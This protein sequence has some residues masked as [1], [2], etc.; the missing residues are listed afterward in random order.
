[1][2]DH[3]D[4]MT[5]G[6]NSQNVSEWNRYECSLEGLPRWLIFGTWRGTLFSPVSGNHTHRD[7]R[8]QPW[9]GSKAL[10]NLFGRLFDE[11][12]EKKKW[13]WLISKSIKVNSSTWGLS[14]RS[15]TRWMIT[16]PVFA[17]LESLL[18]ERFAIMFFSTARREIVRQ[19][20]SIM[21]SSTTLTL[22]LFSLR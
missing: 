10:A 17:L 6:R 21:L 11:T 13:I 14:L 4:W 8:H 16:W 7:H 9:I 1:M 2:I 5:F 20:S 12:F 19:I 22:I 18:S 3:F 15:S